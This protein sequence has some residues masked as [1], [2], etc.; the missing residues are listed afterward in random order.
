MIKVQDIAFAEHS[1]PDLERMEAFLTDFGMV[2]VHRTDDRLYMRGAGRYPYLH[3]SHKGDPGFVGCA[4]VAA[5]EADLEAAASVD[6]ASGVEDIDG[7]GGGRR[8]RL[9]GP[10]GFTI[11]VVHGIGPAEEIAI[12]DP[13]KINFARVKSRTGELQRPAKEPARVVRLGHCVFKMSDADG[14][15]AWF[16]EAFGMLRSDRL[17]IPDDPG[18]TL[19][20]FLRCDRGGDWADHHTIFIIHAPDDVKIHHTSYETQDPDA[21]QIGHHWMRDKEWTHEWGVGRH[22]LGSQVFD[23]WRDPWGH[24][25]EHYADGDLLNADARPGDF[26]ASQE[27]LAQWGPEVTPTFFD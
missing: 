10:D 9:A 26:A 11:S 23:Y 25:F 14:A 7:P 2:R 27:N 19:G 6:G 18:Q 17:F 4:L 8:V 22:L 20:V 16:Q 24:M 5:S 21:V 3:V 13:L 15:A 12:R 1:V